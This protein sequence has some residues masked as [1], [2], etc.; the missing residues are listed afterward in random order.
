M[1]RET[2]RPEAP[3]GA[4]IAYRLF[5]DEDVARPSCRR[6]FSGFRADPAKRR[7]P[8]DGIPGGTHDDE[9]SR[10]YSQWPFRG[11]PSGETGKEAPGSVAK[12]GAP[13]TR[14]DSWRSS[15]PSCKR[16]GAM[17]LSR[18]RSP[19]WR[20]AR[21]LRDPRCPCRSRPIRLCARRRSDRRSSTSSSS[22]CKTGRSTTISPRFPARTASPWGRR[23][24]SSTAIPIRTPAN[25]SFP[26]MIRRR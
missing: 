21:A 12:A 7:E 11:S 10:P 25:A 20:W 4:K 3:D 9:Y 6:G 14:F 18:S 24:R 26:S 5:T 16:F 8:A 1:E 19:L 15:H 13:S 22:K 23:G 2:G 17:R